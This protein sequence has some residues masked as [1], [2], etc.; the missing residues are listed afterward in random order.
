M[1]A[2]RPVRDWATDFDIF[3]P[4]W[5][6]DPHGIVSELRSAGCPVART[7]RFGGVSMPLGH[8]DVR[9]VAY[10]T[11]RFSS[12]RL[13]VS[14]AGVP[15]D[16]AE[17]RVP[18]LTSDPPDHRAHRLPLVAPMSRAVV[19]RMRPRMAALCGELVDAFAGRG[20]FDGSHDYA[21]HIATRSIA[22]LLGLPE[23]DGD[24][25]HR[26]LSTLLGHGANDPGVSQKVYNEVQAYMFAAFM[27]RARAP[28]EDMITY[29]MATEFDFEDGKRRL[30]PKMLGGAIQA[31][32]FAGIDTTW[33]AI[34]LMLL[35]LA[36]HPR[37]QARLRADPSV[38]PRAVEEMLRA[39]S[40]VNTGRVVMEDTEVAGCPMRKGEMVVVSY[41][42]ANRDPAR[43]KDP[44]RVD[45]D[46]DEGQHAAFG[47]GIHRCVGLHLA[48]LE[49]QVAID[50]LL[51]RVDDLRLAPEAQAV[52]EPGM[53][54]G[55]RIL[56]LR[57]G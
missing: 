31:V 47:F 32:L 1:N 49:L 29:L 38:T 30:D 52:W 27:E 25:F 54:H 2:R 56:P 35:H 40:P 41:L 9:A 12:R 21:K 3:D 26:W 42:A 37:D 14:D 28:R 44:D 46:R 23:S 7:E 18:P 5:A 13:L 20:A 4:R 50:V 33:S 34:G 57:F 19:E 10:D 17:R 36:R 16:V 53:I 45:F 8:D 24:T 11:A 55:P 6:S 51:S 22:N 48:R 39:Y 15:A 43:F